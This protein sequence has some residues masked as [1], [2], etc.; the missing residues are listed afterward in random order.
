MKT[1]RRFNLRN[2]HYFVTVVTCKRG[3]ILVKNINLFWEC[4][5]TILP[6]AWVILPDH[7]HAIFKIDDK[8]ISDLIH[9]FKVTYSRRYRDRYFKGR[10]WQNRFWD[11]IIRDQ[12]DFNSHLDY[13]HYNPVKHGILSDPFEYK[14]SSLTD[15]YEAGYYQSDWGVAETL[16]FKGDFGE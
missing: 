13:V 1:L 16:D 15:Y 3:G 11:H 2:R 12:N 6:L 7:F 8:S 9:N 10:V 4:W 14:H 5:S